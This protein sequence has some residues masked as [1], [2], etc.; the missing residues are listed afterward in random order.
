MASG[1]DFRPV[2]I[3]TA[4]SMQAVTKYILGLN[5]SPEDKIQRLVASFDLVGSDFYEQMFDANSELFDSTVIGTAD[6]GEMTEQVER[7]AQK[8][9]RNDNLGR[10]T[11]KLVQSFY[12]SALGQAQSKAF[13]NAVS[14]D[15]HPTLTRS[16][17]GETCGWCEGLAGVHVNPTSDMFSRHANCDC[18][19]VASGYNSRNG[20]VTNYNKNPNFASL[21]SE[22]ARKKIGVTQEYW[23]NE[24]S[25]GERW[26]AKNYPEEI[27]WIDRNKIDGTGKQLPTNDYVMTINGREYELKTSTNLKYRTVR[28]NIRSSLKNGTGIKTNFMI[29]TAGKKMP[30]SFKTKLRNYATKNVAIRELRIFTSSGEEVL[31]YG[32]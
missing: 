21:A 26:F 2:V 29:S 8:I 3:D 28:E 13:F 7:L 15:K 17:V 1:I 11:N 30:D 18:L 24:M 16:M 5:I 27:K 25:D 14:L 4:K 6:Y 22:E 32:K 31:V 12:D 19:L 23:A 20:V 10:D 9:V